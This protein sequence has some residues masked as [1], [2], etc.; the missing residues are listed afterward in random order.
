[1]YSKYGHIL[2]LLHLG[3]IIKVLTQFLTT[4]VVVLHF[5]FFLDRLTSLKKYS[6]QICLH[7]KEHQFFMD[8][9]GGIVF[10][11]RMA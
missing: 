9:E 4:S 7:I 11:W 5:G 1:M 10:K 3:I 6:I 2:I 8:F